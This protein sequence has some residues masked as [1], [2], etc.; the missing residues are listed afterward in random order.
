MIEFHILTEIK[1]KLLF[2]INNK[3]RKCFKK[4][5]DANANKALIKLI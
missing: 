3:K 2:Y 4:L 5:S 1:D